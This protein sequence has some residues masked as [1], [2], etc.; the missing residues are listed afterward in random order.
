M[1]V[2]ST[3]V[4]NASWRRESCMTMQLASV[5]VLG[6]PSSI[7]VIW[8]DM[9]DA[10]DETAAKKARSRRTTAQAEIQAS[11]VACVEL[12]LST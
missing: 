8:F 3:D 9:T 12:L 2:A 10:L 1:A 7:S 6:G 11:A 4:A 5:R